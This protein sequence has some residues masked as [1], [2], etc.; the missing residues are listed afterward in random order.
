MLI[1]FCNYIFQDLSYSKFTGANKGQK[2]IWSRLL[3]R[4]T[5]ED[6]IEI[7]FIFF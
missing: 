4:S 7:Y 5:H 1:D 3:P 6:S 2:R